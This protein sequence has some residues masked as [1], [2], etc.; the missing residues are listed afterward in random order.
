MSVLVLGTAALDTIKTPKGIRKN[1]LGGSAVHF[2]LAA[3]F[4]T[5]V[6]LVAIVGEDF[7]QKHMEFLR[8]KG[9]VLTS[10]TKEKGKTFKW[11]GEYKGDLSS[12][13]TRKTELGVLSVFKPELPRHQRKIEY[14]F[15]A[16]VDPEIQL[17]LLKSIRAPK[18]VAC[19]SMNYWINSKR[20][21]LIKLLKKVDIYVANEA[22]ARSL[23]RC[24]DLVV[25]AKKLHSFG[26]R[27]VVIKMG[28]HGLMLSYDNV[29]CAL[30]AYPVENLVDPTG[31][32][33][34]F[35]GG[36]MG[37]LAKTRKLDKNTIVKAL[38]YGTIFA[39]YNIGDFGVNA[40]SNLS[41]KQVEKRMA[42]FRKMLLFK[43]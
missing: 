28:P 38:A 17:H 25:A 35:A 19:D 33:D 43:F 9:I 26:P 11:E 13:L 23:C 37:Y 5:E 36:F 20:K 21:H 14:I 2:S 1:I 30:P 32:G 42:D 18:L 29:I 41:K 7:P 31:A 16:N 39:S 6:H 12:A 10:L 34:S 8:K 27:F 22:E 4:F 40:V 3:R 24:H 15:L